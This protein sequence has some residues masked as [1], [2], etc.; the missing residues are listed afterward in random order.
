MAVVQLRRC[1]VQ[2]D[3]QRDPLAIQRLQGAAPV[4]PVE[5]HAV[6]ENGDR[7]MLG[8]RVDELT[9]VGVEERLAAGDHHLGAV[10]GNELGNCGPGQLD[11]QEPGGRAR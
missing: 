7:N 5:H 4:A 11:R 6:G 3:L 9:D 1:R 10:A 2:R 8:D